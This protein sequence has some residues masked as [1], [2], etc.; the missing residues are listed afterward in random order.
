MG[1]VVP[2]ITNSSVYLLY[3]AIGRYG[4]GGLCH[5]KFLWAI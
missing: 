2:A 1:R 5:P 4:K 3:T